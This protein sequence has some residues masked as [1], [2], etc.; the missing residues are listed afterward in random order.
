MT[1]FVLRIEGEWRH[2]Q[3][4]AARLGGPNLFRP[5]N[6]IEPP[7]VVMNE[8]LRELQVWRSQ[9][10]GMSRE[11]AK[12]YWRRDRDGAFVL[13]G[14]GGEGAPHPIAKQLSL[15]HPVTVDLVWSGVY[16]IGD[17]K[18]WSSGRG[19]PLSHERQSALLKHAGLTPAAL[20]F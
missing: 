1:T 16:H 11:P 18:R 13:V 6:I 19:T 10:W 9:H 12:I 8:G 20:P 4:A 2:A 5:A 3:R 14:K 17:G 7:Y 15:D